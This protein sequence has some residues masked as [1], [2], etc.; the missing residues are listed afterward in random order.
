MK[1]LTNTS[2]V[3]D[4]WAHRDRPS[5]RC[6][7]VS[8]TGPVLFSYSTP[9]AAIIQRTVD[10]PAPL[11][12]CLTIYRR[13]SVITSGHVSQAR[14]AAAHA[15][16]PTIAVASIA[17]PIPHCTN[18]QAIA[19]EAMVQLRKA[20]RAKTRG[21]YHREDARKRVLELNMYSK[22]FGLDNY[23]AP[24]QEHLMER[25]EDFVGRVHAEVEVS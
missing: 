7:N 22:F 4:A 12:I 5:G 24:D 16:I 14:G 21:E 18:L 8:F 13:H 20:R 3:I 25:L 11:R 10:A 9:V 6:G 1:R 17:S 23:V 15:G 19:E 2:D